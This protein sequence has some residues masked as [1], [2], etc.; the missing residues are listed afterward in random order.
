MAEPLLDGARDDLP[1]PRLD[2]LKEQVLEFLP[3]ESELPHEHENA[4]THD[5]VGHVWRAMLWI[6]VTDRYHGFRPAGGRGSLASGSVRCSLSAISL[7]QVS[8][9]DRSP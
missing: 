5:S 3:A 8:L 9:R 1:A 6:V 4:Q 7:R 2:S